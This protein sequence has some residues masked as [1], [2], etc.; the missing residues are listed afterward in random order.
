MPLAF[1]API[2]LAGAALIGV[3][4]LIHQIRRPEREPLKFSS[5]MF[6]PKI[7]RQI[8]ERRRI[9][10]ILL[11]LLRMAVFLMLVF[12]FSR[13]YLKARQSVVPTGE[14]THHIVLLDASYSMGARDHFDEAKDKARSIASGIGGDDRVGVI[15]FASSPR[16]AAPLKDDADAEAGSPKKAVEAIKAARLSE[17]TTDY[18]SALQLAQDLLLEG[19][20]AD[21][22][23]EERLVIHLVSDFQA[24]GM[25]E[26]AFGWKLSPRILLES[27]EIGSAKY[28]NVSITDLG[29]RRTAENQ[30]RVQGKIKNWS[31]TEEKR[32]EVAVVIGGAEQE[33]KTVAISPKNASQ[34]A[35]M[36]SLPSDRRMEGWLQIGRDDLPIDNRRY[37]VW[38]PPQKEKIFLVSD[39]ESTERWPASWF[40]ERAVP[41]GEESPW[42]LERIEPAALPERLINDE[43]IPDL[44]ILC[45]AGG[46]TPEVADTI[47]EYAREGGQVFLMLGPEANPEVLNEHLFGSVGVRLAGVR[48]DEPRETRFDLMTWV[49]FEHP[50]FHPF[51]GARFNDFSQ[52]RFYNFSV[53]ETTEQK[54]GES[55]PRELAR[56]EGGEG[57][58]PAMIEAPAGEGR[59]L[60]W[61]FSPDLRWT[62]LPKTIKFVPMLHEAI[63]HLTGSDEVYRAWEVGENYAGLPS[64][65][66]PT[67]R[68]SLELPGQ[69]PKEFDGTSLGKL[70][71]PLLSNSGFLR[72]RSLNDPT[73]P[74]HSAA[75]NIVA[76]EA[77][78]ERITVKEFELRLTA[79]PVVAAAVNSEAPENENVPAG[80]TIKSEFWRWFAALV[81][82]LLLVESWYA[83]RVIR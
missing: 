13:P 78:P 44:L 53:L 45:D 43:T 16:I 36:L 63:S 4:W 28:D 19:K 12:A 59:L 58:L 9:Q 20:G 37:F 7:D 32:S 76:N 17:Q 2:F 67:G 25:P 27:E 15:V 68:W 80:F 11:M 49:D 75:V 56:L 51:Q 34:V 1:L 50:A 35:F 61:S 55:G 8:I 48:H 22:A 79:A 69:E 14:R 39:K 71:D 47:S 65:A 60:V 5:L 74:G 29:I 33:K 77:D 42:L 73:H 3:P 72:W 64:P 21:E 30:I 40:I 26:N 82:L 10:H 38:D 62:N 83:F 70:G 23:P 52:V 31:E 57:E 54:D 18:L 24:A 81:L 41:E 66:G 6:I 46:I